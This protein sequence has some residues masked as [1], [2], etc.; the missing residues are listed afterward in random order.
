MI[1]EQ[2]TNSDASDSVRMQEPC[3]AEAKKKIIPDT[4]HNPMSDSASED[5]SDDVAYLGS[6]RV[7]SPKVRQ[8]I[9]R[10]VTELY[11]RNLQMS[12]Q[13]QREINDKVKQSSSK[14]HTGSVGRIGEADGRYNPKFYS[15]LNTHS[16]HQGFNSF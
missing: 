8:S 16:S 14:E 7:S 15:T 13:R 11:A 2:H 6:K 9:T 10:K 4:I 12:K 1:G 3:V 5:K